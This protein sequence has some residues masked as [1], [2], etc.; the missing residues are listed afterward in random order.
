[1]I[2]LPKLT[3]LPPPSCSICCS[4]NDVQ[5]TFNGDP[6]CK[7]CRQ[8]FI[9]AVLSNQ[10]FDCQLQKS[11]EIYYK[12][13]DLCHYC[14][15]IKCLAS[16]RMNP[17]MVVKIGVDQTA[18]VSNGVS[19]NI[20][21][22]SNNSNNNLLN[23]FLSNQ[24][25]PAGNNQSALNGV[26]GA[27]T[28]TTI[29][30]QDLINNNQINQAAGNV[31][32]LASTTPQQAQNTLKNLQIQNNNN[33][34]VTTSSNSVSESNTNSSNLTNLNLQNALQQQNLQNQLQTQQICTICGGKNTVWNHSGGKQNCKPCNTFFKRTVAKILKGEYQFSKCESGCD[35]GKACRNCRFLACIDNGM[36]IEVVAEKFIKNMGSTGLGNIENAPSNSNSTTNSNS[37]NSHQL[38]TTGVGS[39]NHS[40]HD[41]CMTPTQKQD[42]PNQNNSPNQNGNL[43]HTSTSN[44]L[45]L[46]NNSPLMSNLANGIPASLRL[47][48]LDCNNSDIIVPENQSKNNDSTP[49]QIAQ[50]VVQ[51]MNLSSLMEPKEDLEPV[52]KKSR[53][54]ED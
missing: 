49:I 37:S 43:S 35:K 32:I 46:N 26:S 42:S 15:Y 38:S 48:D 8:F 39:G 23:Q 52:S 2:S 36:S 30:I 41:G 6:S 21:N 22:N 4:R 29:N 3:H 17:D 45:N 7:N 14:W 31:T 20:N 25:L 13:N 50:S 5:R 47:N 44:S 16:G 51:T 10:I 53:T 34:V 24:N 11:C 19:N 1:M 18:G 33:N 27:A 12:F 28:T 54:M 9:N 40:N